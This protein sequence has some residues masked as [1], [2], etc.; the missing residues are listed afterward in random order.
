MKREGGWADKA[1]DREEQDTELIVQ[2]AA[3]ELREMVMIDLGNALRKVRPLLYRL[4]MHD[5]R[6]RAGIH[7]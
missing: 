3:E 7:E 1:T 5:P 6:K 2:L 4:E